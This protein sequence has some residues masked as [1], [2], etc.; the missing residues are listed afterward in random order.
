MFPPSS[1]GRGA[2]AHSGA[3]SRVMFHKPAIA[4]RSTP[5]LGRKNLR[6][7]AER[8]EKSNVVGVSAGRSPPAPHPQSPGVRAPAALATGVHLLVTTLRRA[9][10]FPEPVGDSAVGGSAVSK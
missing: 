3:G 8:V 10:F 1:A 7:G 5:E 4:P 2:S 9:Q 6:S